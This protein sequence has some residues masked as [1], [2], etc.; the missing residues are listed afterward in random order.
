MNDTGLDI[1]IKLGQPGRGGRTSAC[2]SH[3]VLDQLALGE[4]T[5]PAA[6]ASEAH[7][8]G[9]RACGDEKAALERDRATFLQQQNL[10]ALAADALARAS[11][12]DE[13]EPAWWRRLLPARP[14]TVGIAALGAVAA[15]ALLVPR[16]LAPGIETGDTTAKGGLGLGV[17]VLHTEGSAS[18]AGD[19][20]GALHMGE[21]L[22]P[23]DRI[24]LQ[25]QRRH[26]EGPLLVFGLD[27]SGK[28]SL[29]HAGRPGVPGGLLPE[30]IELDATL[31]AETLVALS[32]RGEVAPA[33]AMATIERAAR[34]SGAEVTLGGGDL[35]LPCEQARYVIKK[36]PR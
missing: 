12:R 19:A 28:V 24:R 32:C 20:T 23:G 17:Y 29:Y 35:G 6:A 27:Q 2:L 15:A 31:G 5:G 11:S 1:D 10:G 26:A 9:C 36:V 14:S 25:V 30:A 16:L 18:P 21:A 4:L 13:A 34:T 3:A 8:A 33:V 7:L 22:H